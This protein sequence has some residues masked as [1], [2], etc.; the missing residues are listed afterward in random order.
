MT[1]TV[2]PTTL[3]A[4]AEA[5]HQVDSRSRCMVDAPE[6][7]SIAEAAEQAAGAGDF[8]S[9]ERLLR[10]VANRQESEL[11]PRHPDLANT[12]NNL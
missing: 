3:H 12:F 11:G 7:Q 9:A 4:K 5:G 8:V 2:S 6:L 10:E 1:I